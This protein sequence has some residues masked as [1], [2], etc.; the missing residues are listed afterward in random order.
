MGYRH[1]FWVIA[2]I[3]GRYRTLAVA[4][5]GNCGDTDAI[6]GYWR[7]L[8]IFGSEKNRTL[9]SHELE[10]AARQ[11]S[12]W[13]VAPTASTTNVDLDE[14]ADG[15]GQL[16]PYVQ[17]CLSLGAAFD[18]RL[19]PCPY[20]YPVS[21]YP[22]NATPMDFLMHNQSGCS[23]VDISNL[24]QPRYCFMFYPSQSHDPIMK[25]IEAEGREYS[26][27]NEADREQA[28]K[29][30]REEDEAEM[31]REPLRCKPLD[32]E[33]YLTWPELEKHTFE[34]YVDMSP[35]DLIPPDAL[36]DLW[37][38]IPWPSEQSSSSLSLAEGQTQA[39]RQKHEHN[40]VTTPPDE[41]L[42]QRIFTREK[43]G[44]LDFSPFPWLPE[45]TISRLLDTLVSSH[46][47]VRQAVARVD[48]SGNRSIGPALVARLLSLCPNIS[49]LTVLHTSPRNLPLRSLLEVLASKEKMELHHSELFSAA[50]TEAAASGDDAPYQGPLSSLPSYYHPAAGTIEQVVFLS[51]TM[52]DGIPMSSDE[53]EERIDHPDIDPRTL[54][55][56]GGGLRWSHFCTDDMYRFRDRNS[57]FAHVNI[58][59][60]DAFLTHSTWRI[61]CR[62]CCGFSPPIAR[63][64][65]IVA[66]EVGIPL[67]DVPSQ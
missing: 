45:S 55:L 67:S 51:T 5:S 57:S 21:S 54:R 40:Q 63:R 25:K 22:R 10:H 29:E 2:L 11:E 48:L 61:G 65:T 58:P 59:L 30:K 43:G 64:T 33:T 15:Q 1:Q 12:E 37:P 6:H 13:W 27:A 19:E 24:Q 32:P 42:L 41:V 50:Y 18:S 23:V 28:E 17:T 52:Q 53:W 3:N 31:R 56:P 7:L 46:S 9:L 20:V 26:W 38:Q 16:F 36:Y 60:R 4:S 49:I 34:P 47:D 8:Q 39:Y 44:A 14:V 66:Y 62:G 35:W